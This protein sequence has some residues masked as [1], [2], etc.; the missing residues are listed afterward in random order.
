MRARNSSLPSVASMTG[1]SLVAFFQRPAPEVA[2]DLIGAPFLVD[3]VGGIIVETESYDRADPASHSVRGPTARNASMFGLPAH[4]YVYRS[5]GIHW[6]LNLVCGTEPDG[7][8]VLLRAL[9]PVAGLEMMRQRR[10]LTDRRRLCS[11]PGRLCQA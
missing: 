6:C 11:G 10:G 2:Y 1:P 4:L 9:E 8:A 7:S 3:G 5:Y